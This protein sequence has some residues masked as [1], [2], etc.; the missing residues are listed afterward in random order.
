MRRYQ[1]G[2]KEGKI[3]S[4]HHLL[5]F[6]DFTSEFMLQHISWNYSS[7]VYLAA[8]LS[9]DHIT[10]FNIWHP[11]S[12]V[13]WDWSYQK[14]S[15]WFLFSR[16]KA[17]SMILMILFF[18]VCYYFCNNVLLAPQGKFSTVVSQIEWII[19][20]VSFASHLHLLKSL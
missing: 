15:H 2:M 20:H 8:I 3:F 12:W 14:S 18:L 6:S 17:D 11:C 7:M 4:I 9:S 5:Q 10:P 16:I 19:R 13:V 1:V